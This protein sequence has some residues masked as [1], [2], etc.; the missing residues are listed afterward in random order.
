MKTINFTY[1]SFESSAHS[2]ERKQGVLNRAE[3]LLSYCTDFE[4]YR[5]II[6]IIII[7]I[8]SSSSS[9][10]SI[11]I[12][13]TLLKYKLCVRYSCQCD[14]EASRRRYV[15]ITILQV[16][17][18]TSVGTRIFVTYLHATFH[19]STSN[20][21]LATASSRTRMPYIT[22]NSYRNECCTLSEDLSLHVI[23]GPGSD[24][25]SKSDNLQY[26]HSLQN[27]ERVVSNGIR[28]ILS[29]VEIDQ[30]VEK[31]KW[32]INTHAHSEH[33]SLTRQY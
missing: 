14:L 21:P 27:T 2:Q 11:I 9:S 13:I 16:T 15:W 33:D 6:T 26:C 20:S 10:N 3:T 17:F 31:L 8:S 19:M 12:I 25:N 4:S 30:L 29:F 28:L 18:H 23:I 24:P 1:L 22:H 5:T 7:I 32:D